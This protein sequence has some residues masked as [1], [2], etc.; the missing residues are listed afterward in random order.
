MQ[1]YTSTIQWTNSLARR[2]A[3]QLLHA[4]T[5]YA[6]LGDTPSDVRFFRKRWPDFF[7]K[8]FY[9]AAERDLNDLDGHCFIWIKEALRDLWTGR[10][11]PE[12][13]APVLVGI[14]FGG[15][16]YI[17]DHQD[18]EATTELDFNWKTGEF[19]FASNVKFHQAMWLLMKQT[20]RARVCQQCSA[21]FV[22][23]RQTQL[24][25]SS[26]CSELAEREWKREWWR[27]H[28]DAWREKRRRV[29]ERKK[30]LARHGRR[31]TKGRE[32]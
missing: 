30:R 21:C 13:I 24:Y 8:S 3:N 2:E 19:V 22:A 9:D 25:C 15:L 28:G 31:T 26:D 20:W 16:H 5:E 17:V 11:R 32:R 4:L 7:P 29:E 12:Y 6:N 14:R 18:D 23:K 1:K 27:K 10:S